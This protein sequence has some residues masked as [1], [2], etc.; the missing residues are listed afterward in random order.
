MLN[1]IEVGTFSAQR[2]A[3]L[4]LEVSMHNHVSVAVLH[5][6]A[7]PQLEK[8]EN[9]LYNCDVVEQCACFESY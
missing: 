3:N 5:T 4:W 6:T 9:N 8:S 7:K 2:E 1:I